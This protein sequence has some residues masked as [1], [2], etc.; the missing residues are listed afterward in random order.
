M[1]SRRIEAHRDRVL[2]IW[3]AT[4]DITLDELPVEVARTGLTVS[5]APP[6]RFYVRHG[7]TPK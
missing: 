3:G 7:I 2:A 1:R 5:N 4:K 6:H